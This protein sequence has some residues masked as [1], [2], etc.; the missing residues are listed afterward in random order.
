[1]TPAHFIWPAMAMARA[2]FGCELFV[3]MYC[4][5]NRIKWQGHHDSVDCAPGCASEDGN[6]EM[7]ETGRVRGRRR[8]EGASF[9]D[10]ERA[11]ICVYEGVYDDELYFYRK[12]GGQQQQ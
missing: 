10:E 8:G 9:N 6:D 5:T 7:K 12:E 2:S 1:M 3:E 11:C 4:A